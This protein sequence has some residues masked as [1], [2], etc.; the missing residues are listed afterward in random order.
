MKRIVS[1]VVFPALFGLLVLRLPPSIAK[2]KPS[3]E[4]FTPIF[5]GKTLTGWKVMRQNGS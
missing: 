3:D 1:L 5:D 2:E 4:G